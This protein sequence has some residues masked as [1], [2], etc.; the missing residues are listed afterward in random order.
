MTPYLG[1]R[2]SA[3]KASLAGAALKMS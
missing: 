3:K 1:N 2:G